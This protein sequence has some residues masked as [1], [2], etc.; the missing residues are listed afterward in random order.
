MGSAWALVSALAWYGELLLRVVLLPPGRLPTI[1]VNERAARDLFSASIQR[2][3]IR[4][5]SSA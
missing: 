2:L 1:V 3:S 5:G 4:H